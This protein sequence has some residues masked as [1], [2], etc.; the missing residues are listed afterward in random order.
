VTAKIGSYRD[1]VVWQRGMALAE[2]VYVV[3]RAYPR[4]EQFGLTSQTRRAAV[5]VPANIAE[6][7][8]RGTR[9]S[10]ASFLRV[11]RGSLR[12]LQTHLELAKRLDIA[13]PEQVDALLTDADEIGRMLHA[14]INRLREPPQT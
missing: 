4:D 12:E 13:R 11:A 8:G 6:G 3:T 2:L 1:L 5:S 9:A 14:L 10:Y 7:H